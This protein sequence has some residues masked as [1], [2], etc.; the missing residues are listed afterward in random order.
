[1]D[2]KIL[3]SLSL[4]LTIFIPIL[5]MERPNLPR[6]M[7]YVPAVFKN[8]PK[9][10]QVYIQNLPK[11]TAENIDDPMQKSQVI[12]DYLLQIDGYPNK[13]VEGRDVLQH[14]IFDCI[15]NNKPIRRC[16]PG[17][18]VDSASP[19]KIP[20]N[21]DK[22]GFS[23]GDL[24]GLLTC[25]HISCELSRIHKP[26]SS[27]AIYL[28]PFI[29]D[30]N[31]LC[32]EQLGYPQFSQ[33][34]IK[35]HHAALKEMI[36]YLEP[37]VQLGKLPSG[38]IDQV[39]RDKYASL[40]I[41]IDPATIHHYQEFAEEDLDSKIWLE[42]SEQRL[43]EQSK[44]ELEKKYSVIKGKSFDEIKNLPIYKKIKGTLASRKY[45]NQVASG[46]AEVVFKGSQ[47]M[48]KL[49][50]NEIPDYQEQIRESIRPDFSS[51][52]KKIGT[53]IIYGTKGT[54][55]HKTLVVKSNGVELASFKELVKGDKQPKINYYHIGDHALPYIDMQGN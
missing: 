1:M 20:F 28:E 32:E 34:R 44:P 22:D 30:M 52:Q 16:M 14:K 19:N 33:E 23:C 38:T 55:W 17:F 12:T 48:A 47:R 27:L 54:P 5:G 8:L 24:V 10:V 43:F 49:M 3:L 53:P 4:I 45:L 26:G 21:N 9:G 2:R 18:P 37:M 42:R 40:P 36:G 13:N 46:L 15:T 51:V 35:S 39:Y 31:K 7:E 6:N 11:I 50:E 29:D 25:N 41:K